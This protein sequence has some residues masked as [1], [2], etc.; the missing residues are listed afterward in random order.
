MRRIAPPHPTLIPA[1]ISPSL[2]F[3]L[4]L[5]LSVYLPLHSIPGSC[6][7][8]RFRVIQLHENAFATLNGI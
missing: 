1:L 3:S 4:T 2:S 7:W 6:G 5:S 8:Y